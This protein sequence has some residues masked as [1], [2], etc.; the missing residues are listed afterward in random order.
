MEFSLSRPY[1]CVRDRGAS[2]GGSQMWFP[3]RNFQR[4]GCGVI[5][6]A[7]MLLY[8]TGRTELTWQEYRDYVNQTERALPLLPGL[9]IDG[10]RLALG[11]NVC[12]HRAGIAK[13]ARWCASGER[14]WRRAEELLR[15]DVPVLLSVGPNL[16]R[17]WRRGELTFY[18]RLPNG[19]YAPANHTSAHFVVATGL[20]GE[21]MRISSWGEEYYVNR[22]EYDRYARERSCALFTNLLY[23]D[24]RP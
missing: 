3:S 11:M 12:L 15:A 16:P 7:D 6:C 23:L 17:F 8:L 1:L 14:F 18:R 24:D 4:C 21:W 5:A 19:T 22:W 20:D 2:Y 13:R 10:L 9:G